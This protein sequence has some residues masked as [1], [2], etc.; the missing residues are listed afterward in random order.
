M[1]Y[2]LFNDKYL[3]VVAQH[4][5]VEI[6]SDDVTRVYVGLDK[7]DSDEKLDRE[8]ELERIKQFIQDLKEMMGE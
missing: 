1:R 6:A 3:Y 8:T 5:L 7:L 4:E 2:I